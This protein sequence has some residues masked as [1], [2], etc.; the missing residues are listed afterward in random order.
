M[1]KMSRSL[2]E[3]K[4]TADAGFIHIWSVSLSAAQDYTIKSRAEEETRSILCMIQPPSVSLS[5]LL[6]CF[7]L[8]HHELIQHQ[9]LRININIDTYTFYRQPGQQK[10]TYIF[11]GNC[12]KACST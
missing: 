11:W 12:A 4:E 6:G 3:Q 5:W 8:T 10:P 9:V 2:R 1:F 7:M